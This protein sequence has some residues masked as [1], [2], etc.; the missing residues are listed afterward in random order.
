M[1]LFAQYEKL[2]TAFN[3]IQVNLLKHQEKLNILPEG[4]HQSD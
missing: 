4:A 3:S 2:K 1:L